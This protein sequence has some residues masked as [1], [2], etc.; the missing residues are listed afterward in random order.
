[1]NKEL[2]EVKMVGQCD[3]VCRGPLLAEAQTLKKDK[4]MGGRA[5]EA[6][7]AGVE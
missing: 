2:Q 4:L 6:S 3:C 5:W 7:V 1:M